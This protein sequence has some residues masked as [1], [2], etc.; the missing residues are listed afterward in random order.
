MSGQFHAAQRDFVYLS[1]ISPP[2]PP[3]AQILKL[4]LPRSL[5][6]ALN[7]KPSLAESQMPDLTPVYE[8]LSKLRPSP[9][10]ESGL[11]ELKGLK[12]PAKVVLVTNGSENTTRGYLEQAGVDDLVD[13][14]LSCDEVGKSKPFPDVY[15]GAIR[16]CNRLEVTAWTRSAGDGIQRWFVAAH[17]W[18]LHAAR[19]HG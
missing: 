12:T 3:I 15:D 6:F 14:V 1:I 8:T 5:A 7:M 18:D 13:A 2:A 11:K 17:L 10:L 19:K 16:V 4:T 9:G